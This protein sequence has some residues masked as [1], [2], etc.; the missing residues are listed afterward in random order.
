MLALAALLETVAVATTA[1]PPPPPPPVRVGVLVNHVAMAASD[2]PS[3]K[4]TVLENAEVFGRAIQA[5]ANSSVELLVF[6]EAYALSVGP[7]RSGYWE[8]LWGSPGS[9]ACRSATASACPL[10]K[11]LSCLAA[12]HKVALAYNLFATRGGAKRIT[13]VAVDSDGTLL[14][15]YDKVHL[16]P[17]TEALNGATAGTN[18]PTSFELLGRRWG[19]IIC[20]EGE[21]PFVS[22]NWSQMNGLAAQNATSWLW[23]VGSMVSI[24]ATAKE[25][26][27]EYSV[28]VAAT[29]DSS[30]NLVQGQLI[31]GGKA[32]Q[33]CSPYADSALKELPRGY[34][35]RPFVRS[36]VLD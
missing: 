12:Q 25:L 34:T 23:S 18:Q 32:A 17:V 26:A 5:A 27:R 29:Q 11:R 2:G 19:M 35:G 20:Y 3:S 28:R 36:A 30:P 6:P 9:N 8:P 22:G 4:A 16:F 14:A 1:A 21:Y 15:T 33:D 13:E 24:D 31:C 7:S 10:Q